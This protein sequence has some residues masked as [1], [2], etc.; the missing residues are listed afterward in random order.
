MRGDA[1]LLSSNSENLSVSDAE[2]V[3]MRASFSLVWTSKYSWL[4][5]VLMCWACL[6]PWSTQ[7]NVFCSPGTD[8]FLLDGSKAVFFVRWGHMN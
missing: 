4:R 5:E 3:M 2:H 7:S 8:G 6:S 1:I